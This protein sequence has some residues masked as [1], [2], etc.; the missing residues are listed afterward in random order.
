MCLPLSSE[1]NTESISW[2]EMC[3]ALAQISKCPKGKVLGGS[4][5]KQS[6]RDCPNRKALSRFK[7]IAN[8]CQVIR[9]NLPNSSGVAGPVG[10]SSNT[11]ESCLK[12][13]F[14]LSLLSHGLAMLMAVASLTEATAMNNAKPSPNPS[15]SPSPSPSPNH[16]PTVS[17]SGM[18]A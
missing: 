4:H 11:A 10:C 8:V 18:Y 15:P 16:S 6:R 5:R 2:T 14:A 12:V 13:V 17:E 3:F 9:Q 1:K 7:L